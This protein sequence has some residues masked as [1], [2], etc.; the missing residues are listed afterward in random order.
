[1]RFA[2]AGSQYH[3]VFQT[4]LEALFLHLLQSTIMLASPAQ[5]WIF[6]LVVVLQQLLQ[7]FYTYQL[8]PG[9][10]RSFDQSDVANVQAILNLALSAVAGPD[11]SLSMHEAAQDK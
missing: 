10:P 7:Y 11:L 2:P 1:R 9:V 5:S 6:A 4:A 3:A 8:L